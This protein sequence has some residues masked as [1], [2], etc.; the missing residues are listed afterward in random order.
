MDITIKT[1]DDLEGDNDEDSNR[2]LP[3]SE[4]YRILSEIKEETIEILGLDKVF[5]RPKDLILS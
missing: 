5:S 3:A 4:A 1:T 2:V